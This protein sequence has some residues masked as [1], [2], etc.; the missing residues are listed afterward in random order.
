MIAR[1]RACSVRTVCPA[2]IASTEEEVLLVAAVAVMA[3][4]G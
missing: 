1:L 4:D 3:G 2:F